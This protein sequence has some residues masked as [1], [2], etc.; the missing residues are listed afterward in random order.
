MTEIHPVRFVNI[1]GA[2]A[3]AAA[4]VRRPIPAPTELMSVKDA[5]DIDKALGDPM[6]AH[7]CPLC[8]DYFS[9]MAFRAHAQQC[10]DARAPRT[11]VWVPAGTKNAVVTYSDKVKP[12]FV[13]NKGNDN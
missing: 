8:N 9:S 1:K 4:L 7:C 10:I 12:D 5:V 2:I 13:E 6:N 11:R 3:Q